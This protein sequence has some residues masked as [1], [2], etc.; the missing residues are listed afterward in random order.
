M[1]IKKTIKPY[2]IG[3][4]GGTCSGKTTVWNKISEELSQMNESLSTNVVS[5]ISQ[6]NYY[7]SGNNDTNF[8]VPEAIDMA[9]LIEHLKQIK[10][11][12]AINCP[13]Y[14]FTTHQRSSTRTITV[15]P[16]P[17]IVVEGI[18]I[19]FIKELRDLFDYKIYVD[20]FRELR[21][22]RRLERDVKERGRDKD[23]I[24]D[25][26]FKDV[27]PSNYHYVEPSASFANII[28][29]NN[30]KNEFIGIE[31]I[32]PHIKNRINK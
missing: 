23:E 19:F 14:D 10:S 18:L 28:I 17:I 3:I 32:I 30:T 6:D 9:L 26:Y 1:E 8:D 15:E 12:K 20:A 7:L 21:F 25:R 2:I 4:C 13:T 31:A 11:G 5:C 29:M 24:I 22:L 16:T 27:L